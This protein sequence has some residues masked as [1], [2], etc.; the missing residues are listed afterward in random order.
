MSMSNTIKLFSDDKC[1]ICSCEVNKVFLQRWNG[2][3]VCKLCIQ[4]LNEETEKFKVNHD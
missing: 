2:Q 3:D 4:E 1:V